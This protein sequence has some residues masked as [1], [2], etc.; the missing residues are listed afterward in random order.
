MKNLLAY[1][2]LFLLF[3]CNQKAKEQA[4]HGFFPIKEFGKCGFINSAGQTVIKCQ[5]DD[6]DFF[7]E[8]LAPVQLNNLWGFIDTTGKI[9]IQP[10][11]SR[12][13]QFS[14]S[15]CF[16]TIQNDTVSQNAFIRP[17][18]TIA[19]I[20]PDD[21]K[22]V[23]PFAYGRATVTINQEVCAIDKS[24]KLVFN[25]HYP[26]GGG[27]KFQEGIIRVSGGKGRWIQEGTSQVWKGDTT[28]Y[29]DTEGNV[30]IAL[31][32]M[33]YGAFSEGLAVVKIN[34]ST[35]YIDRTGKIKIR[36]KNQDLSFFD[37]SNGLAQA[38]RPGIKHQDGFID[39][40]GALIIPIQFE[41]A[42][43]F[44]EELAAFRQGDSS[45]F[46]NRKGDVCIKPT[47]ERVAREGFNNGL[48]RVKQNHQWGYI[49]KKGEF[50]W[51]QQFGMEYTK[52]DLTQWS[53]DSLE[54]NK[55]IEIKRYA[56]VDNFPRK[57]IFD[58]FNELTLKIDTV[59]I[60]VFNDKYFAYKLYL[61]NA[62]KKTFEIPYLEG[63]INLVQ[64]A[65]NKN[66]EWQDI[67][68]YRNILEDNNYDTY[69]LYPDEFQILATPI[70]KGD[71]TTKLRFKFE[72]NKQVLY[73]NIYT[74]QI[75]SGQLSESD[76]YRTDA[77]N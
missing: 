61:I 29:Y 17:D 1:S 19:F 62:S 46:I 75:N 56:G 45:G 8:G 13:N 42:G 30:I 72:I 3:A 41:G 28:K 35:F 57:Q 68:I 55:P 77:G 38:V 70:F 20:L 40:T 4:P 12:V 15:L 63:R 53:L 18:G 31:E 54:T 10:K 6:I 22:E 58:S 16:V 66:G 25:T 76:S 21:Y 24:G 27:E 59:D 37:F 47:F 74:G 60:T 43:D 64:Q 44:K 39:T 11:F 65:Q 67:E 50:V 32:G 23:S 49:N 9:V 7:S 2:I 73:S 51:K 48:C 71:F 26:Y 5:F 34:D 14:D 69:R 36:P 33:G 52:L